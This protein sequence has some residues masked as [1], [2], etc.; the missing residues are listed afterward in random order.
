MDST[1]AGLAS[2]HPHHDVGFLRLPDT[3]RGRLGPLGDHRDHL[4]CGCSVPLGRFPERQTCENWTSLL[5][6][7]IE[8]SVKVECRIP[9][10]NFLYVQLISYTHP[11]TIVQCMPS[12]LVWKVQDCCCLVLAAD[13]GAY[14]AGLLLTGLPDNALRPPE[15]RNTGSKARYSVQMFSIQSKVANKFPLAPAGNDSHGSLAGLQSRSADLLLA[16]TAI[17]RSRLSYP[18]PPRGGIS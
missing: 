16:S 14:H 17:T 15:Q 13:S 9:M 4:P 10:A 8:V 7:G 12:A 3:V 1:S 2:E 5:Q 18:R 6:L 11:E